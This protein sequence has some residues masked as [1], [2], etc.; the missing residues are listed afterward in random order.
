MAKCNNC[1]G[2]G[3]VHCDCTSAGGGSPDPEC[4][5]CHGTGKIECPSCGGDGNHKWQ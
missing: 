3:F 2:R 1:E 4:R 5:S